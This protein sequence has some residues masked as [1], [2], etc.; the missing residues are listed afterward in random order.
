MIL[1]NKT[2]L[3]TG[4]SRGIGKETAQ[5]LAQEGAKLLLISQTENKLKEFGSEHYYDHGDLTNKEQVFLLL[6][7]VKKNF[8]SI[9]ILINVAG[10]GVYKNLRDVSIEDWES[11]FALNVTA[12]F[13]LTQGLLPLLQK[14]EDPLVLNIGSGMGT[15]PTRGRST[16]CATKFA[17]RGWSLS[18]T[19]EFEGNKPK[20]CLITLGS[21][22]TDFG[23][24]TIEQKLQQQKEGKAYFAIDWVANKLVE[25]IKDDSRKTEIVL[26]PGD[27]GLGTQ[28]KP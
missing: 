3:I 28:E 11:S 4:A 5:K 27:Y 1:K 6:E 19:E 26:F 7:R 15:I 25:I 23:P 24:L 10:I 12:P 17:L 21:T 20:F 2:I 13:L 8:E 18:L 16:Y 9:D 22:L 14:A